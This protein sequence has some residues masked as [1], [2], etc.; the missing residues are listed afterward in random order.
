MSS[1]GFALSAWVLGA[2]V[3]AGA[4]SAPN[5]TRADEVEKPSVATQPNPLLRGSRRLIYE[6]HMVSSEE[7][8][9][10]YDFVVKVTLSSGALCSGTAWGNKVLTSAHCGPEG[11]RG[12]AAQ[13][14]VQSVYGTH[15]VSRA[16]PHPSYVQ[17]VR[18]AEDYMVL[19]LT[20]PIQNKQKVAFKSADL[21]VGS[22]VAAAGFGRTETGSFPA[23]PKV[24]ES[25]PGMGYC[26]DYPT[27][28]YGT[29]PDGSC[30]GDSGGPVFYWEPEVCET[31]AWPKS[32]ACAI[33][34][35]L[36]MGT[37]ALPQSS[38]S[39]GYRLAD[40]TGTW[41][42]SANGAQKLSFEA[43]VA[44]CF[45]G[46]FQGFPVPCVGV[47]FNAPQ[48]GDQGSSYGKYTT[49]WRSA[50]SGLGWQALVVPT[51][52]TASAPV[53]PP[54]AIAVVVG[55]TSGDS[56]G[57]CGGEDTRYHYPSTAGAEEWIRGLAP[58]V[59]WVE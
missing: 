35:G 16:D 29:G 20:T 7:W 46:S 43:A 1:C 27:M 14:S 19:T 45:Q 50:S 13:Y 36:E 12:N 31:D 8:S 15:A 33:H 6:G 32:R 53:P 34:L 39:Q 57:G 52:D 2:A 23:R 59:L 48:P 58:D 22:E 18:Q 11:S 56:M 10:Q 25:Y 24:G 37:A 54:P 42:S 47:V 41:C 55:P 17:G 28:C 21:A 38:V 4:S 3:L 26:Y 44:D 9:T 49:C 5:S 51:T 40:G 30:G